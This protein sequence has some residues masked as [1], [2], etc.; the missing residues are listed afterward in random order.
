MRLFPTQEIKDSS[1]KW[2]RDRST[3][4]IPGM[5]GGM[6]AFSVFLIM[7]VAGTT[8]LTIIRDE[9]ESFFAFISGIIVILMGLII[10]TGFLLYTAF[11]VNGARKELSVG[12]GEIKSISFFNPDA[13]KAINPDEH[14][15][16]ECRG[17]MSYNRDD[18]GRKV[19]MCGDCGYSEL[20]DYPC[21]HEDEVC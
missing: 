7:M 2:M 14:S 9:P 11:L 19:R 18:E 5:I 1:R 3:K 10:A 16:P 8:S 13:R 12:G 4:D 6:G 17:V 15:C 20:Y 21:G